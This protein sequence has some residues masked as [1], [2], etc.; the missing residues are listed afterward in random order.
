MIPA[1]FIDE[2]LSRIDIVDVIDE[3][4]PLKKGGQNYLACCP[5]HKEKTPSFTVSPSKQ[6]YHCFGCGAHGTA[7]GFLMEYERL[8]FVE[9]VQKLADRV[10][11]PV[12]NVG[13]QESPQ[14]REARKKQRQSLE[15]V[16]AQSADYYATTLPKTARAWQYLQS[17]GLT[18]EI[19]TQFHLGYA[20]DGWQNLATIFAD[21]PNDLLSESG[22]I[23]EKDDRHYDRFRDRI[24]FPIRNPQG[25]VVGF[26]GR[27]LDK[28]EP[29]YLNSP[30]TPL[31]DKGRT[32][33]GLFEARSGIA[34]AGKILVVEGYMDVVALAQHGVD[35][36]VASLGTAT[37]E[38]HIKLLLRQSDAIYFCFDGDLAGQKAAWRALE[39]ALPLLKDDKAL[40]FLFLPDKHDPDS[41]IRAH[42]KAQF[43]GALKQESLSLS[44]YWLTHLSAQFDLST[45]EGK[46]ALIRK[47]APMLNMLTAENLRFLMMQSIAKV[48]DMDLGDIQYLLGQSTPPKTKS[49]R[50]AKLPEYSFR[51]PKLVTLAQKQIRWL[52]LNPQWAHYVDFPDYLLL[53]EDCACLQ[54]LSRVIGEMDQPNLHRLWEHLRGNAYEEQIK[55]I[56]A[57]QIDQMRELAELPADEQQQTEVAEENETMFREG[58]AR[59]EREMRNRQIT[60]LSAKSQ[61]QPLSSAENQ[62]LLALLQR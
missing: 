30:Q 1:D 15:S 45:Q 23:N 41:Y 33:Y 60:E 58:M 13:K 52:M 11:L 59:I 4:V 54:E 3:R 27:I 56:F 46:A 17:R 21:Y 14:V 42:G 37:T 38:E 10:G 62:L 39:N 50:Q 47:A 36:A 12:P 26:G 57:R 32:L 5:F 6:F 35:Y 53:S 31:F 40:Y 7:L 25:Q 8:H 24:M 34:Q 19:I 49:Y 61:H 48:V 16:L 9:A 44:Q 22:M 51:Q 20:P 29:K 55:Q 2:L 28:G 43:E 18:A